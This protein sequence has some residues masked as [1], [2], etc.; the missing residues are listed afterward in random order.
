[1]TDPNVDMVD[2]LRAATRGLDALKTDKPPVWDG[3]KTTWTAWW[4]LMYPF[5][6]LCRLGPTLQGSNRAKKDSGDEAERE[7]YQL[8]NLYLWR[9]LTRA[10]SNE[11]K[12][13]EALHLKIQDDFKRDLD[14]Y[15]LARYMEAT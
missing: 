13:G 10:L 15:E 6:L 5:L 12:A 4:Y 9:L 2:G 1:M 7:S 3:R 8:L 11:T 14:G